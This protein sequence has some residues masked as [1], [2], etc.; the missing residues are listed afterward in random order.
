MESVCHDFIERAQVFSSSEQASNESE[1]W[2]ELDRNIIQRFFVSSRLNTSIHFGAA[3]VTFIIGELNYTCA[4]KRPWH[5]EGNKIPKSICGNH[6]WY[7]RAIKLFLMC[8]WCSSQTLML[9]SIIKT[10]V[11]WLRPNFLAIC[12]PNITCT[13]NS[14]QLNEDYVCLGTKLIG[15]WK[16]I[17]E[18]LE[19][20]VNEKSELKPIPEL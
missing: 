4:T 3:I 11:G 15:E 16:R 14:T 2:W 12:N 18:K 20:K 17:G 8:V 6:C 9:T 1:P 19:W 7:V 13:A 10:E 5:K